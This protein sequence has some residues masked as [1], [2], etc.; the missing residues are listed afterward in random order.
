M[1]KYIERRSRRAFAQHPIPFKNLS[2]FLEC[3]RQI[4]LAG[5]P[6]YQ[7]GSAG[8]LYPVQV[9]LYSKAGRIEG[10]EHAIYYYN[11]TH[12]HLD[13]VAPHAQIAP[14]VFGL[15]NYQL[16]ERA[17]FALF[18][19]GQLQAIEP[20]YGELSRDFCLLEAG[21][22]TQLLEGHAFKNRIALR[23]EERRVGK[24]CR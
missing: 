22:V 10:I 14:H 9:Y 19:V 11:P 21:L 23:S 15:A 7:W 1:Q 20:L 2:K 16:F 17:A 12:H 24:E 6:K 3:L 4:S 8:C 5:K 13:L 18:L